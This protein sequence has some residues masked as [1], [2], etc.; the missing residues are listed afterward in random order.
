MIHAQYAC[1]CAG[2][3]SWQN[4]ADKTKMHNSTDIYSISEHWDLFPVSESSHI[5]SQFISNPFS[6]RPLIL[7]I[8]SLNDQP[9]QVWCELDLDYNFFVS[10]K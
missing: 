8:W 5:F 4:I 2:L 3:I 6:N 7:P 10:L 1:A 9:A